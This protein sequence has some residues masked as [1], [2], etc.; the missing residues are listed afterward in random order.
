MAP[1]SMAC[2]VR[3]P[4]MTV[5]MTVVAGHAAVMIGAV[6]VFK[7]E[8]YAGLPTCW[9]LRDLQSPCEC[10][11]VLCGLYGKTVQVCGTVAMRF[12]YMAADCAGARS[13][14]PSSPV[15]DD[16][17]ECCLSGHRVQEFGF[18]PTQCGTV[19]CLA[20]SE[21]SSA[22]WGWGGHGEWRPCGLPGSSGLPCCGFALPWL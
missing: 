15:L 4:C 10:V 3:M 2:L 9:S 12:A 17:G 16:P 5:S 1:P 11:P 21:T 7:K 14:Q 22:A 8:A 20:V 13:T 6:G 18:E 19:L